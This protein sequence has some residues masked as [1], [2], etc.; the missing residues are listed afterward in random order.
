MGG[1]PCVYEVLLSIR[2]NFLS[3][4]N[5]CTNAHLSLLTLISS[6]VN[7]DKC[8]VGIHGYLCDSWSTHPSTRKT[9]T[10]ALPALPMDELRLWSSA[11]GIDGF[12]QL[13]RQECVAVQ[14]SLCLQEWRVVAQPRLLLHSMLH[15]DSQGQSELSS[16]DT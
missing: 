1:N 12:Q 9:I 4:R 15:K 5:N 3:A 8:G 16:C 14:C 6:C 10:A 2:N 7:V 11:C 13:F